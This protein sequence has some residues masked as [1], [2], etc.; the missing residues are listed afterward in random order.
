MSKQP[1]KTTSNPASTPAS[2]GPAGGSDRQE[3]K[4]TLQM[5]PSPQ[6]NAV[7]EK[8]TPSHEEISRRAYELFCAR[9]KRDG[10]HREDWHRAEFELSQQR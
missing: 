4:A 7:K 9:G 5:V 10:H 2:T 6:G 3:A 1:L 8:R